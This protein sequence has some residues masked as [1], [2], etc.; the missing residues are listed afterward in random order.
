MDGNAQ[1]DVS[2]RKNLGMFCGE[3][4]QTRTFISE[5]SFVKIIFNVNNFT[6]E[7]YFS[8]DSR[9]ELQ[10]EVSETGEEVALIQM[11]E[12]KIWMAGSRNVAKRIQ[13][14]V[15]VVNELE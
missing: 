7:T 15:C 3:I 12:I 11:E 5:T 10:K 1:T 13:V 2:N 14:N 6:E 8:F 4:E 9:V